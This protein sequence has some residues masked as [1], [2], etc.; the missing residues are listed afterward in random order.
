MHFPTLRILLALLFLYF[1]WPAFIT[2]IGTVEI[3]FWSVWFLFLFLVIGGNLANLLQIINPPV[4]EQ[5]FEKVK[6][7]V[8]H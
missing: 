7:H 3:I 2:A 4:M 6:Q 8:K 1:A 5:E